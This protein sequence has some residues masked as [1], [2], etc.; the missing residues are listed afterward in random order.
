MVS[1]KHRESLQRLQK[2]YQQ[3]QEC[4]VRDSQQEKKKIPS[5]KR[6]MDYSDKLKDSLDDL[7]DDDQLVTILWYELGKKKVGWNR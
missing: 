3:L 7:F 2:T 5:R 1:M 6:S 4:A